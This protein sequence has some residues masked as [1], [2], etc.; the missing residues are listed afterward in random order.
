[1]K[2]TVLYIGN[3]L[4]VH[5]KS[6]SVIE[7]LGPLLEA[8]YIVK[9]ASSKLNR[10]LRLGEMVLSVIKYRSKADYI[11]IDT[12]ST[13]NFYFA[14][15]ISQM[16]RILDT[17]YIHVL[18]GGNLPHR[19]KKSPFFSKMMFK[20]SYTNIAP[21]NYLKQVFE[22]N[23][24]K[25]EYIPNFINIENYPFKV[26]NNA[27]GK[28]LYVRS[29]GE[30]YNPKLAI[31][32]LL[33]IKER[34]PNIKLCMVG[35]DQDGTLEEVKNIVFE[36][37]LAKYVEFKGFLPKEKWLRLSTEYDIFINTTNFDNTP[38]SVVEAM[39]LGFPIVST[40][41]GGIPFLLSNEE[42]A[43]LVPKDD[44]NIFA[45]AIYRII[46]DPNLTEELSKNARK[47]AES[48]DW[49]NVKEKWLKI[50]K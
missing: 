17:K 38:V 43:L 14:F 22:A 37:G 18:H 45:E 11:I 20:H 34:V 8:D 35:G 4:S 42:T 39:A 12:Y 41:V 33:L 1:M 5:G 49:G 9:Y 2:K 6:I 16:A 27:M 25:T 32:V 28:L 21:S 3:M 48:F 46:S 29:F 7:E 36:N 15:I 44:E 30:I 40:N 10:F 24:Y 23:G 31:K 13:S 19:L 47:K 50:L 26:R